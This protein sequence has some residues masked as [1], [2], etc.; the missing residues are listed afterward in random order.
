LTSADRHLIPYHDGERHG[1]LPAYRFRA[2]TDRLGTI[3]LYGGS[4]SY[5]EEFF[6]ILTGFCDAGYD[7]VA[8]EGRVRAAPCTSTAWR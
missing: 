4:D 2:R 1:C 3:V 8:F 6:P 5:I 7:V